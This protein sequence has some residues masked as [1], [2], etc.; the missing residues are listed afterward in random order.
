MDKQYIVRDEVQKLRCI[1]NDFDIA[2]VVSQLLLSTGHTPHV[3][4]MTVDYKA[5]PVSV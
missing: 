5:S 4:S 3:E 2:Q 1:T